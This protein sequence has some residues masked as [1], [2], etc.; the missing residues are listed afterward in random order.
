MKLLNQKRQRVKDSNSS[1]KNQ[2]TKNTDKYSSKNNIEINNSSND[3]DSQCL[4]IDG[5]NFFCKYFF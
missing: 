2:K 4:N 5:E 3:D 1:I